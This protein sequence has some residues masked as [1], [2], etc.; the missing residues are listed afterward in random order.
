VVSRLVACRFAP[1]RGE[2][3]RIRWSCRVVRQRW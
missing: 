3:H 2:D 1:F